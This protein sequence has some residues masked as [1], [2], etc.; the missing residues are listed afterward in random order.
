MLS[1]APPWG[2][3]TLEE[4]KKLRFLEK[5]TCEG[6]SDGT[7]EYRH[8][9]EPIIF[10]TPLYNDFPDFIYNKLIMPDT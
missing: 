8:E 7:K 2:L 9:E 1:K 4:L 5:L 10:P 6:C 3:A